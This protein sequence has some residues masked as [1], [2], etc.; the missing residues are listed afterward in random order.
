MICV[1]LCGGAGSRLWPLSRALHPKPFL[2]LPDGGSFI[3]KAF[4]YAA[5]MP[6]VSA[7]MPISNRDLYFKAADEYRTTGINLPVFHVLEPCGRNTA[8]AVAVAALE[9][10]RMGGD[11]EL[12]LVLAADHLITGLE[13]FK[14][15]VK[16]A[17]EL[18]TEG[19][20]VTFGI[21]PE[22]PETGYGYIRAEGHKVL[23]FVEKPDRV[24]AEKY[25]AAGDYYWNSGIFCFRAGSMLAEM[26]TCLPR[27]V[28]EAE[29]C[30]KASSLKT[31]GDNER[32]ELD[33]SS[34][35]ALPDISIDYAVMEKSK[36][37]A[38]VP[39]DIGWSDV[40][41]W[42]AF[43]GLD[44]ADQDG[45]RTIGGVETCLRD[46]SGCD[47]HGQERLVVG[48][49]LSD[50]L[51]V[52]TPDALLVANKEHIPDIKAIYGELKENAHPAHSQHRTVTRPWGSYTVLS[53]GPRF[54]V[55]RLEIKPGASISL[56]LHHHRNEHW[57]VVSG[58][59]EVLCGEEKFLVN[60]NESTY[61]KAGHKHMVTN[62]G[63][64]PLVIIEVQSGDYLGEDDIVR[65]RDDYGRV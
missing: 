53:V 45:N 50:L 20:L 52:D 29:Q 38:V 21:K 32:L 37:V 31:W 64:L 28:E 34:F 54:Q 33:D 24:T 55:K 22:S 46:T 13:N 19:H 61:I 60:T 51:I 47:I 43:C 25:L 7:I 40:G 49:G 65:F 57:V 56:Q 35:R 30:L 8:P 62:C 42:V 16:K 12:V 11:D 14:E 26:D 44:D 2:R 36:K 5:A 39:C 17:T 58:T 4:Q 1:I 59:A 23:S 27:L 63:L 18:S 48:L 15:A 3:Q 9:A 10:R 41:S 6:G